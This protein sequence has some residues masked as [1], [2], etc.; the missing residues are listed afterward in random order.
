MSNGL[1]TRAHFLGGLALLMLMLTLFTSCSSVAPVNAVPAISDYK[2]IP[3]VTQEEIDAIERVKEERDRLVFGM[4][5]SPEAFRMIDT[6]EISGVVSIFARELSALFGIEIEPQIHDRDYLAEGFEAG[7]IDFI[8]ELSAGAGQSSAH[9]LS[10]PVANRIMMIYTNKTNGSIE[11]IAKIRRPRYAF[12]DGSDMYAHVRNVEGDSFDAVFAHSDA[13]MLTMLEDGTVDAFF[14]ENIVKD[15]FEHSPIVA[16]TDYYPLYYRSVSLATAQPALAAFIGVLDKYI[17]AG[18]SPR[19]NEWYYEGD[20]QFRKHKVLSLLNDEEKT[21]LRELIQSGK[22]VPVLLEIENYPNSFWNSYEKE[23][24]GIAV[25][26]LNQISEITGITFENVNTNNDIFAQNLQDLEAGRAA[27]VTDLSISSA[28]EGR[29]LW[30]DE[31]YCT[32]YYALVSLDK[33]PPATMFQVMH[34]RV[35]SKQNTAILDIYA[36]WFPGVD[37]MSAYPQYIDA[38]EALERGEVDFVMMSQSTLLSMTNYLEKPGYKANL[39]FDFPHTLQFGFNINAGVL[40]S[41]VSKAQSATDADHISDN[42]TRKTFNYTRTQAKYFGY[43]SVLLGIVFILVLTMLITK[44]RMNKRLEKTVESRT[45]AL[46]EQTAVA[47]IASRAKSDFLSNMSHEI[48]TPL[49]AVIGMT[50]VTRRSANDP[51]KVLYGTAEIAA[52]STHLLDI[53]ND[54]LDMSKIETGKFEINAEPFRLLPILDEVYSLMHQRCFDK[55]IK[56][57]VNFSDFENT[58]VIGDRLRL[59]QVLINLIG[60]AVKFTP[61][62]KTVCFSAIENLRQDDSITVHFSVEDTGIGMSET[63]MESLFTPFDQT[64][65]AIA[66]KFGGTGLGLAISQNLVDHMGGR[67]EVVSSEGQGSTFAFDVAFVLTDDPGDPDIGDMPIPELQGKRILIA[68][69]I[70]INRII[71]KELLSD[72]HVEIEEAEDGQEA[73]EM[74]AKSDEFYYDLVFMDVQMPRMN[75]YDSATAIRALDRS[76][77]KLIPII[78][79]TANAYR[80]DVERAIQSGMNMHISKPINVGTVISLLAEKIGQN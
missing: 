26:I 72:T 35:A 17:M 36:E 64:D 7:Q 71:L 14:E 54:I 30:A 46:A 8:G 11:E 38:L 49:N 42:W 22:T 29:F 58:F 33:A 73:L 48:R 63:Q 80:E 13:D 12:L 19:I 50:E 25:D 77:A 62:G 59:K 3:D 75:G 15:A 67:I 53:I 31:P 24:Q 43:F 10:L 40:C 18:Y 60:N 74:I 70:E 56:F 4:T 2:D 20:M 66:T 32:D 27:M 47:M 79:V 51:K 78:A 9:S 61:G 16:W 55:N 76:D 57:S 68:E 28:R 45:Q 1:R 44:L 5:E 6:G 39:V 69:D 52:A 37:N 23:F 65:K 21:Y 41:I 34:S